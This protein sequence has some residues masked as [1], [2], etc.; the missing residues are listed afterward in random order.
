MG[1]LLDARHQMLCVCDHVARYPKIL[2]VCIHKQQCHF[3]G[4]GRE[5]AVVQEVD[6]I[7]V[8]GVV[9]SLGEKKLQLDQF[10][11]RRFQWRLCLELWM[12]QHGIISSRLDSAGQCVEATLWWFAVV[13]LFDGS[14]WHSQ[15]QRGP[16]AKRRADHIRNVIHTTKC[17]RKCDP[18]KFWQKPQKANSQSARTSLSDRASTINLMEVFFELAGV[19]NVNLPFDRHPSSRA[20]FLRSF[21]KPPQDPATT[22]PQTTEIRSI[23][24]I[25]TLRPFYCGAMICCIVSWWKDGVVLKGCSTQF[26]WI[27]LALSGIVSLSISFCRCR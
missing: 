5:R 15:S 21:Y 6:D 11:I 23:S 24:T 3:N 16:W 8:A 7:V 4:D 13:K 26:R 27:V 25:A 22:H 20:V 12:C 2:Q 18:S 9:A 10:L 1:R 19:F 17:K 14:N